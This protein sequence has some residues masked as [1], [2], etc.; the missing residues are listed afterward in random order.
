MALYSMYNT[1][2]RKTKKNLVCTLNC[3]TIMQ[4][5]FREQKKKNTQSANK[6]NIIHVDSS[7]KIIVKIKIK[8]R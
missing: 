1:A 6:P 3:L 7:E 8:N 2:V 4:Y 5:N